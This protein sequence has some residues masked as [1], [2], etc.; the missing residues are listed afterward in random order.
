MTI[1]CYAIEHATVL[2]Y[3]IAYHRFL[4]YT[5]VYDTTLYYT[6]A[7]L[8]F[9]IKVLGLSIAVSGIFACT[10]PTHAVQAGF[11]RNNVKLKT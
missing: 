2:Y 5:T 9:L 4:Y 7:W 8:T 11:G 1:P 6:V 3:T 10:N